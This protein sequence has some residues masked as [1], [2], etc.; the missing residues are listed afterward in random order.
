MAFFT[1][2]EWAKA[3]K[4]D[5]LTT[6]LK[7]PEVP[8]KKIFLVVSIEKKEGTKF[9][10]HILHFMDD[11]EETFCVFCP[12]HFLNHIRSTRRTDERPYFISYGTVRR[13]NNTIASFEIS[14][15]A[16][17]KSFEIFK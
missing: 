5:G 14:Y 17:H 16:E 7:W 3:E 1:A 8:Q 10:T 6:I 2:A 15:K 9:D 4:S 12:T 11:K 13:G